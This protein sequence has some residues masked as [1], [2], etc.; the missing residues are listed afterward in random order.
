MTNIRVA[1]RVARYMFDRAQRA[2]RK[3]TFGLLAGRPRADRVTVAT[4]LP[5]VSASAAH[6]E[7]AGG[8][9][10]AA[11]RELLARGLVPWGAWHSHADAP[12]FVS[13]QDGRMAD[14]FFPALA[15]TTFRRVVAG[16]TVPAVL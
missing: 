11:V 6:C 5:P 13:D 8:E 4:T 15:A 12:A 9:L 7:V 16:P 3:E 1:G 10:R 14:T 2:G